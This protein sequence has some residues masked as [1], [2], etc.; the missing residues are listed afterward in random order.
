[1]SEVISQITGTA[2]GT[3]GAVI[4]VL[5]TDR[6]RRRWTAH[7]VLR[8]RIEL[9]GALANSRLQSIVALNLPELAPDHTA[10]SIG[11]RFDTA[12]LS[13]LTSDG[14]THLSDR[15]RLAMTNIL[16][17]ME[18]AD[19][20]NE[21]AV[22]YD[23]D[24]RSNRPLDPRDVGRVMTEETLWLDRVARLCGARVTGTLTPVGGV[25]SDMPA[26]PP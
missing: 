16:F 20:M 18:W 5:V 14:F 26:A 1:M 2:I 10:L 17:A 9:A 4:A 24:R 13:Q 12:V 19:R 21:Q 7:H 25:E 15:Q 3:V 22:G 8:V 6:L 23:A 11:P